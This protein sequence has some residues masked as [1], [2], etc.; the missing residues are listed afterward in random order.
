M[1]TSCVYLCFLSASAERPLQLADDGVALPDDSAVCLLGL[2][3]LPLDAPA[4]VSHLLQL[5]RLTT[6]Q[7]LQALIHTHTHSERDVPGSV[8]GRGSIVCAFIQ[9]WSPRCLPTH[10]V[11]SP[12]RAPSHGVAGGADG[13]PPPSLPCS[14]TSRPPLAAG[15]MGGGGSVFLCLSF[16]GTVKISMPS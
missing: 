12:G 8:T 7:H 6:Q 11:V 4:G 3:L 16:R 5:Q 14:G 10:N 2:L 15:G 1:V 13:S 9:R